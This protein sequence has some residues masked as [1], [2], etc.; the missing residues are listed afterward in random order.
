MKTKTGICVALIAMMIGTTSVWAAGKP[1]G[2]RKP[3]AANELTAAG[4]RLLTRYSTQ[5]DALQNEILQSLPS[6]DRQQQADFLNAYQDEAAATAAELKALRAQERAKDKAAAAAAYAA[7]KE[8]RALAAARA[9]TLATAMLIRLKTFL[10]SDTLDAQLAKYGVLAA[11]TPRGL[12]EFAQQ[13]K[14][15]QAL[16]EKLLADDNLML[17]MAIAGGARGGK[18]GQAMKI[19]TDIQKASAKAQTGNLQRLALAI[20]LEHAV[21]IA[22]SNPADQPDAPAAGKYTLSA[23]V[24]TTSADQ[25]LSVAIN[26]QTMA[27][28]IAV[29]FTVGMWERTQPVEVKLAEGRNVLCFTRGEAAKGLTIKE[30]TLKPVK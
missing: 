23:R 1:A 20:S 10:A 30:F 19:Y 28:D 3:V 27:T 14:E 15:H 5:L 17:Q 24:V 9:K 21:P 2:D 4:Q 12:A 13:G 6:I 8:T 26:E 25:H 22:Q 18:V 7:A 11:A 29:P 16:I